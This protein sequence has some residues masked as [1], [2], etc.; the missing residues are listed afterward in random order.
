MS[1]RKRET[2]APLPV[3]VTP[4]WPDHQAVDKERV[5]Y[6]HFNAEVKTFAAVAANDGGN[7]VRPGVAFFVHEP[8][9]PS[10]NSLYHCSLRP[11]ASPR[12]ETAARLVARPGDPRA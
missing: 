9:P 8:P 12:A 7:W 3:M 2:I 4:V 1:G 10:P 6:E 11:V 5:F